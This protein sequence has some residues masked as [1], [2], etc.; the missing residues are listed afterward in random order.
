MYKRNCIVKSC[1]STNNSSDTT[2]FFSIPANYGGEWLK[3]IGRG[4]SWTPKK[5]SKICSKHFSP[6]MIVNKRLQPGAIPHVEEHLCATTSIA[7]GKYK[8]YNYFGNLAFSLSTQRS[9]FILEFNN[10]KLLSIL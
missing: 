7:L 8:F 4:D 9:I 1:N 2:S 10:Y 5:N 6:H 3:V